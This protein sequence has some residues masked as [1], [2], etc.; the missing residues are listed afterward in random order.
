MQAFSIC[1]TC[2]S[3]FPKS[4]LLAPASPPSG[5]HICKGALE[6]ASSMVS[7]AISQSAGFEWNTFAVSSSFPKAVFIRE[8]SVLDYFPPG[9]VTSIKNSVNSDLARRIAGG[10]GKKGDPRR[11]DV[12]FEFDFKSLAG[13]AKPSPLYVFGHYLKLSRKHCQSRWHCS[14]CRGRGCDLC[15]GSGH[16][17][18]SVEEEIGR[19]LSSAFGSHSCTLHASGRE[20]V[21]V[22]MLGGGR[23]FVMEVRSPAKR[24]ADLSSIE[25]EL[26]KNES[27]RAIG[28]RYVGKHFL[29]AVCNSHFEKEYSALVSADRALSEKDAKAAESLSGKTIFQQTP[30]R[31]L[32]RR[33]DMERRRRIISIRAEPCEG[34]KLRLRILAEAGTYI[35]ELINSDKGRTKPSISGLLGCNAICEELDVVNIRDYYLQT[36]SE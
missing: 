30:K 9:K 16:N 4:P 27:V 8:Q 32:S 18:P 19:V 25:K 1:G 23:P 11:P 22:R 26:S 13:A 33:A 10:T 21:D 36:V 5:C 17:Y 2:A 28:L 34:G 3:R 24:N 6:A 7:S 35:K 29:D 12:V 20:D 15:G 31:V 14:V